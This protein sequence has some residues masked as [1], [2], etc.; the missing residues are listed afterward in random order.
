MPSSVIQSFVYDKAE[1]RL[2]VRFVSGKVYIYEGVPED[3]AA[4]FNTAASKGIYFNDVIR[5]R[6]SF[7]QAHSRGR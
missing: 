5:D 7:A 1:C 3:I 2:V 4:G 6:F